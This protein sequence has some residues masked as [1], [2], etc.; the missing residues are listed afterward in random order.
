MNEKNEAFQYL[1][2]FCAI[3]KTQFGAK[4]KIIRNDNGVEFT[5]NLMKK[6]YRDNGIINEMSCVDT[7]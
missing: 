7:P 2:D 6:F 5:S 1:M 3:A 4:V